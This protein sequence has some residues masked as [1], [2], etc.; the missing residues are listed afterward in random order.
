MRLTSSAGSAKRSPKMRAALYARFS[1]DLQNAGSIADQLHACRRH[2]ERLGATVVATYEDAAISGAATVN[3]PG[4]MKLLAAA[5][6]GAFDVVICEA[7]D[8]LTRSGGAAWEIFED[9]QGAGVAIDTIAEGRV[10]ELAVGLKGTMNALFLKELGRKTRRG[11]AGVARAGRHAGGRIYGYRTVRKLDAAGEPIRGLREIDEAEA[12]VVREVFRRYAAGEAPRAIAADLNDRGLPGPRGGPWNASTI[13]GNAARGNGILHNALYRGELV[14]GRHT[15]I[16]DRKTGRRRARTADP[17]ALVRQPVPELR[18]VDEVLWE[19][20]R[21]RY[22][23]VSRAV[24]G[25]AKPGRANRPRTLFSGLMRCS[26]GGPMIIAGPDR[27]FVCSRRRERGPSACT[28]RRTPRAADVEA[29]VLKALRE[30]LLAPEM[31]EAVM[32]EYQATRA[33][34][35]ADARRK[36]VAIERDLAETK[37]RAARLVDQLADGIVTGAA[38]RERL[39]ELEARR[40]QLETE[41]DQLQADN[42]GNVIRIDPRAPARFRELVADLQAFLGEAAAPEE[43]TAERAAAR[44]AIRELV[45]AVHVVPLNGRGQYRLDVEGDLAPLVST[46]EKGPPVRAG[47]DPSVMTAMG[48]GTRSHRHFSWPVRLAA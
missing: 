17:S 4:L 43:E 34:T 13:N 7:L 23:E 42:S 22:A 35:Q 40:A 10:E 11:Q 32:A 31:V 36:R 48:A 2:A 27:R 39:Q 5:E 28:N 8:R 24:H 19:A 16:K 3:R 25:Q 45:R 6:A 29:R 21:A 18:I 26:C 38:I 47:L 44:T 15:W 14:W 9:L 12:E 1:S 33:A 41:L 46:N 30:Q 37:R 20:V